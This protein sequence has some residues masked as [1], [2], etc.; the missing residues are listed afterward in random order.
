MSEPKSGDVI[1]WTRDTNWRGIE[2]VEYTLELYRFTLGFFESE[3][4]R[5][6]GIFTPLS[7]RDLWVDGPE[8]EDEYISNFG[9]YRTN[10]VPA[11]DIIKS[12]LMEVG[13]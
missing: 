9:S 11:F 10:Q 4:H 5:E 13:E 7:D 2:T 6:A 3:Q 1:R 12:E 8:S